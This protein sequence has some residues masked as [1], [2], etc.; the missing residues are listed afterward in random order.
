M[1][2]LRMLKAC[3]LVLVLYSNALFAT[4]TLHDL[5]GREIPLSSLKGKWVYINYWASWCQPCLEEIPE[6]NR[7]YNRYKANDVVILGVNY[8]A[9]PLQEQKQLVREF[10]IKYPNLSQD[11]SAFFH[12]GD[13]RGVPV[14]F[15]FNPE[16][17]LRKTLYGPQTIKS[18][19][20]VMS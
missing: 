20:Q 12:I 18:L 10:G 16:G 3:G 19:R 4:Q 1:I 2:Y 14:T 9:L 17:K 7:F 5:Y 15:V 11:P 8:D 6:L 13:I